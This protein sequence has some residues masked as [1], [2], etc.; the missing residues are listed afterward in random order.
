MKIKGFWLVAGFFVLLMLAFCHEARSEV[1][2]EAG[3]T[4]LSGDYADGGALIISERF[5]GRYEVHAGYIYK[6]QVDT[7]G[8]PDC[9]FDIEENIFFGAQRV[10]GWNRFKVGIGMDYFQNRNRALGK[11]LTFSL[12]LGY[13]IGDNYV[14]RIRHMSN[15]GSGA[16]NLGQDMLT[17]GWRFK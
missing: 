9:K 12:L 4:F 13:E 8:R 11:N 1:T 15:A 2:I 6:Q 3:P 14:L 5:L 17:I 16:P 10:A 7:C